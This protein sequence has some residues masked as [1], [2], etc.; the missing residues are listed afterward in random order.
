MKGIWL[1]MKFCEIFW[2]EVKIDALRKGAGCK[3]KG[4]NNI[5]FS[6]SNSY[7][8]RDS[9]GSNPQFLYCDMCG[10]MSEWNPY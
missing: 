7:I 3:Q 6:L 2:S 4:N 8:I 1:Q 5:I 9:S 10:G